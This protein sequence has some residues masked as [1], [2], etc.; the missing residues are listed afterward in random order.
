LTEATN[1]VDL[2]AMYPDPH[3]QDSLPYKCRLSVA[4]LGLLTLL[5]T[6]TRTSLAAVDSVVVF[7]SVNPSLHVYSGAPANGG[8]WGYTSS[9]TEFV[10]SASG[11]LLSIDLNLWASGPYTPAIVDV[12]LV[13]NSA[14]GR[15]SP[16]I[17]ASGIITVTNTIISSQLTSFQLNNHVPLV[18]GTPY[19]LVLSPHEATTACAWSFS[20]QPGYM[21]QTMNRNPVLD[22]DWAIE[23]LNGAPDLGI[24]QLRVYAVPEPSIFGLCLGGLGLVVLRRK[25]L[26]GA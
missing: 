19:W 23:F 12:S 9:A 25:S 4:V 26:S 16:V 5:L 22:S 2:P 10:P 3:M 21:A 15:P 24:P 13:P 1:W 6:G 14:G 8:L 17:L 7:D 20:D 18:A 11:A